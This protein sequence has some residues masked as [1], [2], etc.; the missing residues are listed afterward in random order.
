VGVLLL[1]AICIDLNFNAFA[2]LG[3][4]EAN[5]AFRRKWKRFC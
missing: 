2:I 4:D 3:K 5:G 1:Q